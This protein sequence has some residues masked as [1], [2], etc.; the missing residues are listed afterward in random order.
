MASACAPTSLSDIV[1]VP[2][3]ALFKSGADWS[4]YRLQRGRARLTKVDV[5]HINGHA[6]EIVSGLSPG[7]LVIEHPSRNIAD[8]VRAKRRSFRSG[9]VVEASGNG[10]DGSSDM[11][12]DI[13][14][15]EGSG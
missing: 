13:T 5:D 1:R 3:T 7:D 8:G 11:S 14:T 4:V 10:G 2:M 6:A 15:C 12:E 9:D